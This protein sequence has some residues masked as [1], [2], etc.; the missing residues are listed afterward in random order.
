ML[1]KIQLKW[2]PPRLICPRSFALFWSLV[3]RVP[4][5]AFTSLS[6]REG[7]LLWAT[8][9]YLWDKSFVALEFPDK[10]NF[11]DLLK[12]GVLAI[13]CGNQNQR[14]ISGVYLRWGFNRSYLVTGTVSAQTACIIWGIL[15]LNKIIV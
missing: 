13:V 8:M 9:I 2:D 6:L 14:I 1:P 15:S 10:T 7:S 5:L 11:F 3:I 4:I 12:W